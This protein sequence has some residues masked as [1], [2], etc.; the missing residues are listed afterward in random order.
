MKYKIVEAREC[1]GIV[2]VRLASKREFYYSGVQICRILGY[3]NPQKQ[4]M[5]IWERNKDILDNNSF[6]VDVSEDLY[7]HPPPQIEVGNDE[8][9]LLPITNKN[10][11][12]IRCYN[13]S[14]MY[15]FISQCKTHLA[16]K[17]TQWLFDKL[18]YLEN[19]IE[20][21]EGVEWKGARSE[22]IVQRITYTDAIKI[23]IEYAE[24]HGSKNAFRYYYH[25]TVAVYKELFGF[26]PRNVKDFRNTCSTKQLR[27]IGHAEEEGASLIYAGI[28]RG[29]FYKH[30]LVAVKNMYKDL[31]ERMTVDNSR[32]LDGF[33]RKKLGDSHGDR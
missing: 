31:N 22:G 12:N 33:A 6:L 13:R 4:S 14:G 1:C 16:R 15:T 30:I 18:A 10:P 11:R 29:I 2:G 7:G 19:F 20:K 3:K 5:Q 24:A 32:F 25:F 27:M 17:L 23:F 21:R 9:R 28:E 26:I 8:P